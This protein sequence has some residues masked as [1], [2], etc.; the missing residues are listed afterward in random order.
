[1]FTGAALYVS[2]AEQPA[3]LCLDHQALLTEWKLAYKRGTTMQVP[4]VVIGFLLGMLEWWQT[5]DWRWFIGAAVLVP[6]LPYTLLVIMPTN[7]HILSINSAGAGGRLHAVRT[8]LGLVPTL[9]LLWASI[10]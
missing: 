7:H 3:R 8:L 9:S 5:K 1:V 2:V 4:L 10:R 6:S